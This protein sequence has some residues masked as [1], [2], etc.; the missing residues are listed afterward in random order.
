M[1]P[2]QTAYRGPLSLAGTGVIF[3]IIAAVIRAYLVRLTDVANILTT[4]G[5]VA[6]IIALVWGLIILVKSGTSAL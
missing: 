6:L 3:L 5:V 4:V 1:V 2:L